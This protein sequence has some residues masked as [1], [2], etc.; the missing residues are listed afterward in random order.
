MTGD[1]KPPCGALDGIRVVDLTVALAG[2]F[3]TMLLADLGA[4]VIKVESLQHYSP[5][6]RGPRVPPTGDDPWSF[7]FRRD[8]ADGDPGD[9][10]WNRIS[11][12]NSHARNKRDVTMDLT[13]PEGR[14][15][16]LRLIEQSDGF[17]ENNAP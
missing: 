3:A 8:Y 16:F 15:L 5:P 17:V 14:E 12:F 9:D 4:E 1:P 11:W 2:A 7:S 10:P 6:S 13:R